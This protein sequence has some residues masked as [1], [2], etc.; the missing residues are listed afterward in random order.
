LFTENILA[1]ESFYQESLS[2]YSCVHWS[3]KSRFKP[4]PKLSWRAPTG[5][6]REPRDNTYKKLENWLLIRMW[7]AIL[8]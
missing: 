8:K 2:S 6:R 5:Q 3:N 4:W 1:R 7:I